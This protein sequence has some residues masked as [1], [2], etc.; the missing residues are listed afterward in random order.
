MQKVREE[1]FRATRTIYIER[2]ASR[3]PPIF[4]ESSESLGE[5]KNVKHE[6]FEALKHVTT[7]GKGLGKTLWGL[8]R[9]FSPLAFIFVVI[10]DFEEEKQVERK[11][12]EKEEKT[13]QLVEVE[14]SVDF[15]SI[16]VEGRLFDVEVNSPNILVAIL[17][18]SRSKYM[19]RCKGKEQVEEGSSPTK[20][21]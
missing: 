1:A 19:M 7:M 11:T 21:T 3:L 14:Q 20:V 16:P 10:S 15:S 6:I 18:K 4:W 9:Q 8:W 12:I 5:E 13:K 17:T 2:L